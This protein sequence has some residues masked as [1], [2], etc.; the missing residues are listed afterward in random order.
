MS[1]NGWRVH[2]EHEFLMGRVR[3]YLLR[4]MS[5]GENEV[6]CRDGS[7]MRSPAGAA[8]PD[9][10]GLLLPVDAWEDLV[11]YAAGRSQLGAEN[12]VLRE[13]LKSEAARVDVLMR[14][15]KLS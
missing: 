14:D 4:L 3:L 2:A 1:A 10:A 9:E 12:R 8:L 11:E 15:R 6:V 5:T 7:L 13:W